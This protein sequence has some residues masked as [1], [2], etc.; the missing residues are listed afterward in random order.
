MTLEQIKDSIK[1]IALEHRQINDFDYGEDFLLATGK[2]N[3]YP[4]AFLEIPY[5][6]TYD[7]SRNKYKTVQFAL[8]V[9]FPPSN[10]AVKEDHT[11][12]SNAEQIGDA[13]ITRMQDEFLLLGFL[14]DSVNGLSLREFSDDSVSGFRF[15]IS[16]KIMRSFC[17][18]NYLR[19]I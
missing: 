6:V 4:M 7:L 8:L 10:D 18:N 3:D 17:Q 5:N 11:C 13:I 19:S 2:G 12:I 15:E 1:R 14:I 16:G 9:L